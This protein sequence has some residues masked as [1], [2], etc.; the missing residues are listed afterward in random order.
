MDIKTR[1]SFQFT[2]LVFGILIFFSVLAY[3]FSFT[4]Q[5]SKFRENL[6]IK[7]ENTAILLI[8]V[9][10]VD[11]TLLKIIHQTT[12]S[13]E[14][15]EIAVTD[16]SNKLIYSNELHFLSAEILSD[17]AEMS[18][19]SYF[20]IGNKDGVIYKHK[21]DNQLHRIF[22]IAYDKYRHENLEDLRNILLWSILFSVWLSVTASYFFSKLAIKPISGII[23]KVKEINSSKLNSRLDEGNRKD[24]IEQ[25][26]ITFNEMLSDLEMVFKSQ[27]DFVSNASHELRTPL[28]IMIAESDYI[29]SR[30]R[31]QEEYTEHISRL[32]DD[33]R[34]LNLLLNSLLELAHLNRD[35]IITK[36]DVR[37]DELIFNAIQTIKIK[38]PGRKILP[39]IEYS[40]NE[41]DILVKGNSGL[42]EIAFKNLIDNACKFSED[43]VTVGIAISDELLI[44]SISD[45]GIGIPENE[46][47]HIFKPFNRATNAKYIGGF[48]IGLSIVAKIIEL[49]GAEIKIT[50]IENEG[51]SFQ[52]LF[53]K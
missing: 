27:D 40:E 42:L 10:E 16:A 33:L 43:E 21:T 9:E 18:N 53:K 19:P 17:N 52:I 39:K 25:L 38:Y 31:K 7:A 44:V 51:T 45:H 15:E 29:L 36:T 3:Y 47:D 6:L 1:L 23:T 30:E 13:F 26:S 2:F 20:S 11:S 4:S 50:S 24:E 37:I 5:R 14:E 12:R 32:V 48:G 22:V 35:N 28:A 49:H 8:N 41:Q 46:T 34:K